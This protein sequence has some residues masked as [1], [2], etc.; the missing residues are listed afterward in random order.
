MK[1]Q[2]ADLFQTVNTDA[3][4]VNQI[5]KKPANLNR[6]EHQQRLKRNLQIS[7]DLK[8]G[9]KIKYLSKTTHTRNTPKTS[10][11][12]HDSITSPSLNPLII[13]DHHHQTATATERAAPSPKQPIPTGHAVTSAVQ[14]PHC[15]NCRRSNITTTT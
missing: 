14:T 5:H 1:S 2:L 4:E 9:Q 3:V 6:F 15:R 12:Y 7:T 11:P 13:S 8:N 10:P